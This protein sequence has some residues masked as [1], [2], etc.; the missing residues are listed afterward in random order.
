[1]NMVYQI[2][3]FN[4]LCIHVNK[5]SIFYFALWMCGIVQVLSENCDEFGFV[6]SH[7]RGLLR[8]DP[9]RSSRAFHMSWHCSIVSFQLGELLA[10]SF[11]L[12]YIF[13][14]FSLKSSVKSRA[15]STVFV[16]AIFATSSN[17]LYFFFTFSLI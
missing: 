17:C 3:Q 1:M 11:I 10:F 8:T 16:V 7:S 14:V 2:E 12:L 13:M 5:I 4:H 6:G 15:L 9:Q